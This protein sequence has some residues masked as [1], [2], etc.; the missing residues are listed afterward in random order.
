MYKFFLNYRWR[1]FLLLLFPCFFWGG[2]EYESSRM[3]KEVWNL[4]HILFFTIFALEADQQ[5]FNTKSILHALGMSVIT[6]CMIPLLL[7]VIDEYRAWRDYPVLSYFESFLDTSRWG[8]KGEVSR[9]KEPGKSGKF[10]LMVP[11]TT[12]KYSGIFMNHFPENGEQSP[13]FDI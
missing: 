10:A 3:F 9:V 5:S 11:L 12:D 8:R 6:L 2:P 13:S 4:G 1:L 7:V